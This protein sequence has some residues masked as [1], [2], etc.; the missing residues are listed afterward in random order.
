MRKTLYLLQVSQHSEAMEQQTNRDVIADIEEQLSYC[1]RLI[2]SETRLQLA[3]LILEELQD[4]IRQLSTS[5][6]VEQT[7]LR[8][9]AEKAKLLYHRARAL[10]SLQE[11]A[12]NKSM[13]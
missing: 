4:R 9:V 5:E 7:Q 13:Y 2:A 1:E 6:A 12:Q 10:L 8:S 3:T 11:G